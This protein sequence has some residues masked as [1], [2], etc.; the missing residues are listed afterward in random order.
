[1]RPV[2]AAVPPDPF[3]HRAKTVVQMK[4]RNPTWGCQRI[5]QQ[6]ALAFGIP[7]DKDVVRRILARYY[8]P[9]PDAG[10]PV[11]ANYS[12]SNI[13][14]PARPLRSLPGVYV[15]DQKRNLIPYCKSRAGPALVIIPNPGEPKVVFT[16]GAPP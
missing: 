10:G 8:R 3:G 6:I 11:S 9:G 16:P 5:A 2:Y 7:I 15:R 14:S 1:V 12:E 13:N 4:Q